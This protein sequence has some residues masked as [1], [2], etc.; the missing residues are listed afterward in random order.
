[1]NGHVA[2]RTRETYLEPEMLKTNL[3]SPLFLD[4][5]DLEDGISK[6]LREATRRYIPEYTTSRVSMDANICIARRER[7]PPSNLTARSFRKLGRRIAHLVKV[8][9]DKAPGELM[10]C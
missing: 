7:K 2:F 1:M 6:G 4:K 5:K 10:V 3:K 9:I 8:P